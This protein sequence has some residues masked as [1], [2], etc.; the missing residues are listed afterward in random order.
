ML[1]F[2]HT[3]NTI[4]NR[5]LADTFDR[6]GPY[7]GSLRY[8]A[9]HEDGFLLSLSAVELDLATN[10]TR[11]EGVQTVRVCFNLW[12]VSWIWQWVDS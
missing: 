7:W 6:K 8:F 4:R 5:S 11:N 9:N 3:D 10:V 12:L 1:I 2:N